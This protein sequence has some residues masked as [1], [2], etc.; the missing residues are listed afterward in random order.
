MNDKNKF[1]IKYV[2]ITMLSIDINKAFSSSP[3]NK[4]TKF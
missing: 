3:F 2:T 1:L 4:S